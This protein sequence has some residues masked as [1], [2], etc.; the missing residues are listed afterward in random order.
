MTTTARCEP[1]ITYEP[2][3]RGRNMHNI[4]KNMPRTD[5]QLRAIDLNKLISDGHVATSRG[6]ALAVDCSDA[7]AL[8][9]CSKR[10]SNAPRL[11][12]LPA[13]D[14]SVTFLRTQT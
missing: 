3:P 5:R 13:H 1:A 6:G 4:L 9:L 11:N 2:V 12:A 14:Q 7:E 8:A 10:H